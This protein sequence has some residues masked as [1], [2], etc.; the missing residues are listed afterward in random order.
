MKEAHV[1]HIMEV[2]VGRIM[3]EK[4]SKGASEPALFQIL[5]SIA[6]LLSGQ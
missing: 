2:D 1:G 3:K 6:M 5:D 4:D